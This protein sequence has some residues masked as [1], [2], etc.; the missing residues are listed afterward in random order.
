MR[1]PAKAKCCQSIRLVMLL[2]LSLPLALSSCRREKE[3]NTTRVYDAKPTTL[4]YYKG[5]SIMTDPGKYAHLYDELP[6]TI[7]QL[8]QVVHGLLMH[9]LHT[10]RYGVSLTQERKQEVHLRKVEDM[11]QT[12]IG[13]KD[14]SLVQPRDPNERVISICR[15]YAVLLCSFL[16]HKGVPA[17]ARAGCATYFVEGSHQGHWICEYWSRTGRRW[18]Q[19]DAQLD[20][21]QSEHYGIDFDPLDLP[22][23]KFTYAGI[24][25]RMEMKPSA[26]EATRREYGDS[27]N[28]AVTR[29]QVIRDLAAL[30]KMELEIWDITELMD[31]DKYPVDK[32]STLMDEIAEATTSDG[33]RLSDQQR[34]YETHSE[35]RMPANWNP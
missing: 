30:N 12:L 25:Y 15:D 34:I 35:L 21:V 14:Q 33:D 31:P 4:E 18:V 29:R 3:S 22:A 6:E 1:T 9:I 2:L 17:R 20:E 19:V 5:H 26:I 13:L 16:R 24:V 32:P 7:P 27:E 10:E 8:C 28:L 11:L 23:G